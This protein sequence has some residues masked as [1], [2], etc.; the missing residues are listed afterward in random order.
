MYLIQSAPRS[1]VKKAYLF[2]KMLWQCRQNDP[3]RYEK[4]GKEHEQTLLLKQKHELFK[5]EEK[6]SQL[7][8]ILNFLNKTVEGILAKYP[9]GGLT[10]GGGTPKIKKNTKYWEATLWNFD[11]WWLKL[12]FWGNWRGS[13]WI[14]SKK[15]IFINKN[16]IN[17]WQNTLLDDIKGGWFPPIWKKYKIMRGNTPKTRSIVVVTA[18]YKNETVSGK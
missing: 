2:V 13:F 14:K 18:L 3:L 5:G 7:L 1:R 10:R 15:S 17:Y 6:N 11:H 16:S 12:L 4:R 8:M 9:T